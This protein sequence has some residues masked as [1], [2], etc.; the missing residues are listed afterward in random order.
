MSVRSKKRLLSF[1]L[2][3][4]LVPAVTPVSQSDE[5]WRRL[6]GPSPEGASIEALF[7]HG[8]YLFAGGY[9]CIFRST[10]QGQSWKSVN[11]GKIDRPPSITSF[12]AIGETL[13]AGASGEPIFRSTDNGLTWTQM[14]V[15][16]DIAT[17]FS[18]GI[19]ID[20]TALAAIGG[21]LFAG[22]K[23]ESKALFPCG[24][25]RSTDNGKTWTR[26]G[27]GAARTSIHSLTVG[28]GELFAGGDYGGA[29]LRSSDLGNNWTKINVS[30]ATP[31]GPVNDIIY[32]AFAV[33]GKQLFVGTNYGVFVSTDRG[34]SWLPINRGLPS[35]SKDG[36]K[37]VNSLA[38]SG[39]TLFA[40]FAGQW[41]LG[42]FR[43]DSQ[44]QSW[45]EVNEGLFNRNVNT[46]AVSGGK[47]FVGTGAG[48]WVST[49]K[50]ESWRSA[51]SGMNANHGV[52]E[53]VVR[54]NR[55]LVQAF[56]GVYASADNGNT[57]TP[58]KDS[59]E[60]AAFQIPPE[61][62]RG[63]LNKEVSCLAAINDVVIAG[64]GGGVFRS[65]DRGQ[66]WEGASQGLPNG[67]LGSLAPSINTLAVI[68]AK[69]YAGVEDCGLFIS[70]DLGRSWAEASRDLRELTVIGLISKGEKLF[71]A[72]PED[73][74][75][76]S[77]DQGRHW[78]ATGAF[79]SGKEI[80]SLAGIGDHLLAGTTNDIYLS[81]DEG[82][83]WIASETGFTDLYAHPFVVSGAKIFVGTS[84]GL[85]VSSDQGR[86]WT[87]LSVIE[88]G[89]GYIGQGL[90]ISAL[91]VSGSSIFAGTSEG[92]FLSTDDGR[93][94]AQLGVNFRQQRRVLSLAVNGTDILAGCDNGSIYLS[95]DLGRRWT[96]VNAWIDPPRT[97]APGIFT[98]QTKVL[99]IDVA[100]KTHLIVGRDDGLFISTSRGQTW[101]PT[102]VTREIYSLSVIGSAIFA[103]GA[104][105][106][107]I[108]K[109]NGRSWAPSAVGLNNPYPVE[110]FAVKGDRIYVAQQGVYVSIDGGRSWTPIN[111]GL[112][113]L[114][115]A[116]LV[117]N[118]T[119]IFVRTYH[120]WL[121]T[122][123]L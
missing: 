90:D 119:H 24:I 76:V 89:A 45:T 21:S 82:Q 100:G 48:V 103:G 47:L 57:W 123:R 78:K 115:M 10:D 88:T 73:G 114:R 112:P 122:R 66:N 87:K 79:F 64:T 113:D 38:V 54:D 108:S 118:D 74:V 95:P 7:S 105:G 92:V 32:N 65:I 20:I 2:C 109:D 117:V 80:L 12:T 94:W 46:F 121:F 52:G 75:F 13:F 1:V 29:A 3:A 96:M 15:P 116:G 31:Y 68:G 93:S 102:G 40:G 50:G 41:N 111:D 107:L 34:T 120:G 58:V 85:P 35:P 55:L 110:A 63:A 62:G 91:A 18:S 81:T 83:S 37:Y 69:I 53:M 39:D 6:P 98:N 101:R 5:Q 60:P 36:R 16:D 9:N 51:N 11:F 86:R 22:T 72:T 28:D 25:H 27:N 77:L 61:W 23:C 59:I 49:D 44:S 70:E 106:V 104:G 19:P 4:S 26:V 14:E 84:N 99:N 8:D 97:I 30:I 33:I 71:A 17:F 42:V 67:E 56:D 43:F